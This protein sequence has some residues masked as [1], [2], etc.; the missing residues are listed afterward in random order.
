MNSAL[1]RIRHISVTVTGISVNSAAH[2]VN[3]TVAADLSSLIPALLPFH[4]VNV[5]T[6]N[7][8][9]KI[10]EKYLSASRS[11]EITAFKQ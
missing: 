3:I 9:A 11:F 7:A 8:E 2:Q 10:G 1:L 6:G 5:V 4:G